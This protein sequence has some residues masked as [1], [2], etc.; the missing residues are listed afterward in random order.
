M[1]FHTDRAVDKAEDVRIAV[2][3]P[4]RSGHPHGSGHVA[5]GARELVDHQDAVEWT[6][7]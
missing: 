1:T 7:S 6:D 3:V 4:R 5:Q 2:E